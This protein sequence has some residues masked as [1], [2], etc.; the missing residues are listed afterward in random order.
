MSTSATSF[1][2]LYF[3]CCACARDG[4][5]R[6]HGATRDS[7]RHRTGAKQVVATRDPPSSAPNHRT[8]G[9]LRPVRARTNR[10]QTVGSAG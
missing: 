9:L 6:H 8:N 7:A 5:A 4:N 10:P 3:L 2:Q 1:C